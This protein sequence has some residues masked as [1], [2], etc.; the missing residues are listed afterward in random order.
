[1][2]FLKVSHFVLFL[3]IIF[4]DYFL[5][6]F[7]ASSTSRTNLFGNILFFFILGVQGDTQ[8]NEQVQAK[9]T[10]MEENLKKKII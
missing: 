2:Y 8:G 9:F 4:F 3:L 1:M 6:Y 5:F 10:E 7:R